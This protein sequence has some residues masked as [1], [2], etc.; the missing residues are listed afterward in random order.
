VAHDQ[1]VADAVD[2]R[3]ARRRQADAVLEEPKAGLGV[4]VVAVA[5]RA[6]V[7]DVVVEGSEGMQ[8]VVLVRDVLAVADPRRGA[9]VA[10]I[11]SVLDAA[12]G[13]ARSGTASTMKTDAS[14]VSSLLGSPAPSSI[15]LQSSP[16]AASATALPS[17]SKSPSS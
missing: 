16:A 17:S 7:D 5:I 2:G 8:D 1:Q 10:G 9:A 3:E 15:R 11:Q 12:A 13:E 14:A 6:E 4:A